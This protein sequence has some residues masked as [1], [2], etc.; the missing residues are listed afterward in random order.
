MAP[1]QTKRRSGA[2]NR[3]AYFARAGYDELMWSRITELSSDLRTVRRDLHRHPELAFKEKRTAAVVAGLLREW[4]IEVHQGIGRTGVVGVIA[5]GNSARA[6]GLRADMDAL[7]IREASGTAH[8]SVHEGIAHSCGHDGHTAMLLCAQYALEAARALFGGA[9]LLD[10]PAATSEDFAFMLQRV[11]GA[12]IWLGSRVGDHSPPLHD[13]AFDFNDDVLPV[14]AALLATL[15]E[16]R[17][18]I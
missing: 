15:A 6:I 9:L 14:G 3:A 11:P 18:G 4:G 17:L 1:P 2:A 8:A 7:P 12:Y 10:A 5:N 16:R 13:P